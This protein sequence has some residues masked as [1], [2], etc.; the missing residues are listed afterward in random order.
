M[1]EAQKALLEEALI[2]FTDVCS[3]LSIYA[4]WGACNTGHMTY[5]W[6]T[7][8][9]SESGPSSQSEKVGDMVSLCNQLHSANESCAYLAVYMTY[10][11][12]YC[13]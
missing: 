6:V 10:V 11:S 12:V 8:A 7:M 3:S 2:C 4:V 13:T 9:S 1:N 5:R